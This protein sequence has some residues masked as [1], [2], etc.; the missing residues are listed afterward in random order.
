MREYGKMKPEKISG[1]KKME[2]YIIVKFKNREDRVRLLAPIRAL[3]E[4]ALDIDGVRD[5]H[6]FPGNS[7]R[8]NR[9]DLMIRMTVTLE[10]L[11]RYDVSGMHRE[12]KEKYGALIEKKAIFDCE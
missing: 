10:G 5:V 2:H 12:W 6:I 8:D 4:T 7:Y 3:F 11:E 9:Y 1:V